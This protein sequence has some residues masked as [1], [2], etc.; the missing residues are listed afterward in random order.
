MTCVQSSKC[1]SITIPNS[2]Y[3]STVSSCYLFIVN[4]PSLWSSL[5]YGMLRVKNN[6]DLVYLESK[7]KFAFWYYFSIACNLFSTS[8]ELFWNLVLYNSCKLGDFRNMWS[9]AFLFYL[10]S[11]PLYI[12]KPPEV[13]YKK[14]CS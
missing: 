7:T 5:S 2:F 11:L 4:M 1:S 9:M 14:C 8:L 6:I 12:Q 13:F 3:C 10:G